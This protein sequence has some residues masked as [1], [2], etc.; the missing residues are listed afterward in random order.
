[1]Y[2]VTTP[3]KAHVTPGKDGLGKAATLLLQLYPL[4]DPCRTLQQG[5]TLYDGNLVAAQQSVLSAIFAIETANGVADDKR[6]VI[7]LE[8]VAITQ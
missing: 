1:M 5:L 2:A 3:S 8:Q 7:S 4:I 6:R